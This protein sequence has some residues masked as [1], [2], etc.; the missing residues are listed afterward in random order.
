MANLLEAEGGLDGGGAATEKRRI[1]NGEDRIGERAGRIGGG[2][3]K[4]VKGTPNL[5]GEE[6]YGV[7]RP[8]FVAGF[9]DRMLSGRMDAGM[10]GDIE[11]P[12]RVDEMGTSRECWPLIAD[13]DC[14]SATAGATELSGQCSTKGEERSWNAGVG[15][16]EGGIDAVDRSEEI[17]GEIDGVVET[18]EEGAVSSRPEEGEGDCVRGTDLVEQAEGRAKPRAVA[19]KREKTNRGGT[20]LARGE[21]IV[22][23][24]RG[25]GRNDIGRRAVQKTTLLR[26]ERLAGCHPDELRL[27]LIDGIAEVSEGREVG[28]GGRVGE[29]V[30]L[31]AADRDNIEGGR[32]GGIQNEGSGMLVDPKER[33]GRGHGCECTKG[34]RLSKG[35]EV[36]G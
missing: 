24:G 13:E 28:I 7:E 34:E 15:R 31:G 3:V 25:F 2:G 17:E 5:A 30:W 11:D 18:G 1:G 8:E 10:V 12:Q 19:H 26:G 32:G 21:V 27:V 36:A 4:A 14:G 35:R 23:E 6:L 9:S 29:R 22:G 16:G 33:A 20:G